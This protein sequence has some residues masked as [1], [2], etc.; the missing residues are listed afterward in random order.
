MRSPRKE[1]FAKTGARLSH[2]ASWIACCLG[3]G[4][5]APLGEGD[6]DKLVEEFGELHYA[7]GTFVFRRGDPP[8]KI[9][10]VRTGTVELSRVVNG[11]RVALQILRPGDVP[12]GLT[13]LIE[14]ADL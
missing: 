13:N 9:H 5:R 8:A 7:G 4:Q 3:R 14:L 10:V 6:V 1:T 12:E 11:R 2:Y